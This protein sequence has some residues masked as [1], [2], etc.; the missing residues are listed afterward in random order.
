MQLF[1]MIHHPH[2]GIYLWHRHL[3]FPQSAISDDIEGVIPAMK[4]V[5]SVTKQATMPIDNG[6]RLILHLFKLDQL[7]KFVQ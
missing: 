5:I 1:S 3:I 2:P 4:D 6:K 7:K